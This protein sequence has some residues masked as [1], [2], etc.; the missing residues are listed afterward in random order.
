[1]IGMI[2]T[3]TSQSTSES[4]RR[5]NVAIASILVTTAAIA[6]VSVYYLMSMGGMPVTGG[7][8]G[9]F[10]WPDIG[11]LFLFL[12]IWIV[13]VVA[14][15]FPAM[16]PVTM[17]YNRTIAKSTPQSM[18][19]LLLFLTGYLS[20]YLMLGFF[21]YLAVLLAFSVVS[22]MPFVVNYATFAVGSVLI[23]TGLWQLTPF[24]NACLKRCISPLGFFLIHTRQGFTGAVRMGAEHGYYCVGCCY[25]YMFVMLVVAGMSLP[26][27]ALLAIMIT[28]EKALLKRTRWFNWLVSAVFIALGLMVWVFP[29]G[30]A[31]I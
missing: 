12:L 11:S 7:M 22:T 10:V 14:M 23:A 15:M 5:T 17:I 8:V 9:M 3:H 30:L 26:A 1:M 20:M 31:I 24:K 29:N 2:P 21:A 28:L 13:G 4:F 18:I 16:I 27:M 6:W 25:M 19:G